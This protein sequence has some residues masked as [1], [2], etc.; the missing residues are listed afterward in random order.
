[1]SSAVTEHDI[2]KH[3][4]LP[5]T[6]EVRDLLDRRMVDDMAYYAKGAVISLSVKWLD[7]DVL[8]ERLKELKA[9]IQ[10]REAWEYRTVMPHIRDRLS[11][12]GYLLEKEAHREEA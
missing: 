11:W 12:A 6:W 4:A 1:M 5:L 8:V 2:W 10:A 3:E 7:V 9:A